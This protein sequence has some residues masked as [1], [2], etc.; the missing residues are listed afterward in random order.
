MLIHVVWVPEVHLTIYW[1]LSEPSEPEVSI[2]QFSTDFQLYKLIFL[3]MC[4]YLSHFL[5]RIISRARIYTSLFW[6]LPRLPS[7]GV[8][9]L[10]SRDLCAN[11]WKTTFSLKYFL[12]SPLA[13]MSLMNVVRACFQVCGHLYFAFVFFF[14]E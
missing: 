1:W 9:M 6:S 8:F 5:F 11:T 2:F 4:L 13:C 10:C 12:L 7:S 14:Y 3:Y